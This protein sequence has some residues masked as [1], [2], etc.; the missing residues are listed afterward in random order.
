MRLLYNSLYQKYQKMFKK[1]TLSV[2]T[3]FCFTS[4]LVAQVG[5]GT[6]N[7]AAGALLDIHGDNG[8]I[9]IPRV[10][11]TE[12]TNQAPII[13]PT[14]VTGLMVYNLANINDVT[15][16]FYYWDGSAW[17][18][19]ASGA[20]TD[21]ALAGNAGTTP[22]TGAGENYI[23]TS[24][25]QDVV[26]ATDGTERM[27]VLNDAVVVNTPT[28]LFA[29][30]RFTVVGESGEFTINGY[31]DNGGGLYGS[32]NGG[33]GW[34]V[35]G[36]SSN[37][38]VEGFG[39]FGVI[40]ESPLANAFGMFGV[41]T[42]AAGTGILGGSNVYVYP[43]NGAGVSGSASRI[44]IYGYAGAGNNIVANRGNAAGVFVLDTDSN[45]STNTTSNGNRASAILAGFDNVDPI[46]APSGSRDS[47]FGGYFSG[48]RQNGTPTYAFVGM[49]Y[50]TAANGN[51]DINTTDYKIIGTGI[52]ST[53]IN[54]TEGIPR[55][56]FAPE[57]PEI[58]FQDYGVGQLVNGEARINLDPILKSSLH[59]DENHPLKVF[60]TLEGDCNGV[61]VTDKTADGF[62]VKELQGG[63]S[64][65]P[66]S[67]QIV[68]NRADTK[69]A[70]GNIV[71]KHVGLRLPI[72]PG[73]IK[74]SD[75]NIIDLKSK[76]DI[77]I[78]DKQHKKR[79]KTN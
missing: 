7:P 30:D 5:I 29:G 17:E 53:L 21:W 79:N 77:I 36:E 43:T 8:G 45:P 58:V 67:W 51:S 16:G 27:R 9:V 24:D 12:T 28:P 25:A 76:E 32:N 61:Y 52:V 38:G 19:M 37:I 33:P 44:G 11:L 48:G 74:N 69:D 1:I 57:S 59:I 26:I 65:V 78:N 64:N 47:Y 68:A 70:N 15:P 40:G 54:D 60:V 39:A 23:G 50:R 49:R 18:R 4:L 14:P 13:G 31:T 63:N 46:G 55:I 75:S 2:L 41:N 22:G 56:L 66:F 6:T 34:G 72:G 35:L 10:N 62:T 3:L 20:S 73:Q 42:N 71:S